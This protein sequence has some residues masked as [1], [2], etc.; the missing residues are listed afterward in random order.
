M[1]EPGT[2]SPSDTKAKNVTLPP[3]PRSI[4]IGA[5]KQEPADLALAVPKIRPAPPQRSTA[6]RTSKMTQAAPQLSLFD[7]IERARIQADYK[8]ASLSHQANKNSRY[9]DDNSHP[10]NETILPSI[11]RDDEDMNGGMLNDS[12]NTN[13]MATGPPVLQPWKLSSA[14]NADEN[15]HGPQTKTPGQPPVPEETI[16]LSKKPL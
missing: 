3:T 6:T 12:R 2:Y 7:R 4:A 5:M 10:D 13:S 11:E 1:P 9:P 15:T 16:A 8:L 14:G